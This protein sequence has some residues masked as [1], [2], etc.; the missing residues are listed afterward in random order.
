M[1]AI[2]P[3]GALLFILVLLVELLKSTRSSRRATVTDITDV[4]D[5]GGRLIGKRSNFERR[6]AHFY[7]TPRAACAAAVVEREIREAEDSFHGW[8]AMAGFVPPMS[9]RWRDTGSGKQPPRQASG[10]WV[11][12]AARRTSYWWRCSIRPTGRPYTVNWRGGSIG[13]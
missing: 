10:R 4:T 7:P 12:C 3:K 8:A 9:Y 1:C 2:A 13:K 11:Q 5:P 6:E